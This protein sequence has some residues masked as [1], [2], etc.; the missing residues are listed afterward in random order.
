MISQPVKEPD[1]TEKPFSSIAPCFPCFMMCF[2]TEYASTGAFKPPENSADGNQNTAGSIAFQSVLPASCFLTTLGEGDD[3]P[4]KPDEDDKEESPVSDVCPICLESLNSK[5]MELTHC[6]GRLFH[7]ACLTQ[8]CRQSTE[9]LRCPWCRSSPFFFIYRPREVT[10]APGQRPLYCNHCRSTFRYRDRLNEHLRLRHNYC[11]RCPVEIG[12]HFDIQEHNLE[13]GFPNMCTLC[14][15]PTA[16]VHD[17]YTHITHNHSFRS[18][19]Q[20]CLCFGHR[21]PYEEMRR[22]G[23]SH[24]QCSVC[25]VLSHSYQEFLQ[26]MQTHLP[27]H[28]LCCN[29]GFATAADLQNHSPHCLFPESGN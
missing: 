15:F 27:Y 20:D 8:N 18:P 12:N 25:N 7:A 14:N 26:H 24:Y 4:K 16:N 3:D 6:C 10:P 28:C 29:S 11:W 5:T 17:L 2:P 19:R 22:S 21:V 1:L 13:H 23:T 9:P